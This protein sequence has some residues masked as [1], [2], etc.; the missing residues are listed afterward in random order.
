MIVTQGQDGSPL[1]EGWHRPLSSQRAG[2]AGQMA[3]HIRAAQAERGEWRAGQG[4][5]I[6][7]ISAG[8]E[9]GE[10]A[11]VRCNVSANIFL[12]EPD[13]NIIET[14]SMGQHNQGQG[15]GKVP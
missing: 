4:V 10:V 2:L 14:I 7:E 5:E 1:R 6:E 13:S 8:E 9:E 15:Q 11:A 3:E 12:T